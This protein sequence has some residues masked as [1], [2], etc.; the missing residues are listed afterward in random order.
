MPSNELHRGDTGRTVARNIEDA[1][2]TQRITYAELAD[3]LSGTDWPLSAPILKRIETGERRC[4]VD[5]LVAIARALDR[6]T[7]SLLTAEVQMKPDDQYA[8]MDALLT[9]AKAVGGWRP[10]LAETT[11]DKVTVT[12][13]R[14]PDP[15]PPQRRR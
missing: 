13:V 4:D 6:T 5:D 14:D 2:T 8:L 11:A 1:R 10:S 15:Q 7:T 9:A 3:R 12:W